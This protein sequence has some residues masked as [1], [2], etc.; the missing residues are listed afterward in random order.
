MIERAEY[1]PTAEQLTEMPGMSKKLERQ[2]SLMVCAY[3]QSIDCVWKMRDELGRSMLVI[4]SSFSTTFVPMPPDYRCVLR[5]RKE[6]V[7]LHPL[8]CSS[9]RAISTK[10]SLCCTC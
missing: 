6:T 2:N 1:A 5:V 8:P 3:R 9:G 4:T 10:T 7:Y